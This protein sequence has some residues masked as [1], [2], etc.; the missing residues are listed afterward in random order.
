MYALPCFS[1]LKVDFW[2]TS[3]GSPTFY[4][5]MSLEQSSARACFAFVGV[6]GGGGVREGKD[7]PLMNGLCR[8]LCK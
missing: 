6:M 4:V 1:K 5:D 8:M 3:R 7:L 2:E